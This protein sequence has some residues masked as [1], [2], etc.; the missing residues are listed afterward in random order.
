MLKKFMQ[1]RTHSESTTET[2]A[3]KINLKSPSALTPISKLVKAAPKDE[4]SKLIVGAHIELKD[5]EITDCDILVVEGR[6]KSA[7][8]SRQIRIA[9]GG[10]FVGTAEVDIAEIRGFFDGDL[11]VHKQLIVHATAHIHG[12]ICYT[13]MTVEDGAIITGS[14]ENQMSVNT[15]Q[16]MQAQTPPHVRLT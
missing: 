11:I 2:D 14:I 8:K 10:V 7:I 16:T 1:T 4:G 9:Q 6:V 12:H 13:S 3:P 5:S 15:T